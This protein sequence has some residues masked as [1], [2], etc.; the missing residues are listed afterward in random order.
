MQLATQNSH[1]NVSS[2]S[3]NSGVKNQGKSNKGFTLLELLVTVALISILAGV[4]VPNLLQHIP[5]YHAKGATNDIVG[6]L[7]MARI[8]AIQKNRDFSVFFTIN[9]DAADEYVVQEDT[10]AG[11]GVVWETV[12]GF[13]TYSDVLMNFAYEID[14]TVCTDNRVIFN[15]LGKV[16]GCTKINLETTH[17]DY[18]MYSIEVNWFTGNITVI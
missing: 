10:D 11:A 18:K 7:M 2:I 4:A 16:T 3:S 6:K 13:Q 9:A 8:Q 15:P 1:T 12:T 14:D 5:K 17:G